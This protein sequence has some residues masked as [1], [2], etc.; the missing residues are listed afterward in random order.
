MDVDENEDED[1]EGVDLSW[2]YNLNLKRI[3]DQ[4]VSSFWFRIHMKYSVGQYPD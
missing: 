1:E 4:W 2:K 3:A